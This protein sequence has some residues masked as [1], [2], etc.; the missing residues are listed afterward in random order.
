M[1]FSCRHGV[2]EEARGSH[3]LPFRAVVGCGSWCEA[4]YGEEAILQGTP[5]ELMFAPSLLDEVLRRGFR[6]VTESLLLRA[7]KALWQ[8]E[9]R[10]VCVCLCERQSGLI[11]LNGATLAGSPGP[12]LSRQ[13]ATGR[14]R[15]V[16]APTC[17]L[18]YIAARR[19]P[20]LCRVVAILVCRVPARPHQGRDQPARLAPFSGLFL[21][22]PGPA[23]GRRVHLAQCT[24]R[25]GLGEGPSD[26]H[27]GGGGAAA[28]RQTVPHHQ[29]GLAWREGR[30]F[31]DEAT[32][33]V[34]VCW[35]R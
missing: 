16:G 27:G 9:G 25:P 8:R 17:N 33:C 26:A 7:E 6:P 35:R 11:I 28:T 32:S 15:P 3:G 31:A 23:A 24:T 10:C 13:R 29:P 2:G 34:C 30:V 4:R 22:F 21:W 18:F 12:G 1:R 19:G 5:L 14:R 20:N